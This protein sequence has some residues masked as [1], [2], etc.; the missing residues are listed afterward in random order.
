M[1]K[2]IIILLWLIA[3]CGCGDLASGGNDVTITIEPA[4]PTESS[5]SYSESSTIDNSIGSSYNDSSDNSSTTQKE[6]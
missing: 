1:K 5:Y 4:E 3:L 6:P 2:F